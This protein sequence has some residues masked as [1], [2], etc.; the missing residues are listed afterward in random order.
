MFQNKE[1]LYNHLSTKRCMRGIN[2]DP[3]DPRILT[4]IR[5]DSSD[6]KWACVECDAKY[7]FPFQ[8]FK[9]NPFPYIR[10]TSVFCLNR[11]RC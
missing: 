2:F 11:W 9:I 1:C 5:F 7:R 6:N 3:K 10:F 8:L 4:Y